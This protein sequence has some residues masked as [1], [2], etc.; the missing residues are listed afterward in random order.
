MEP[1]VT[2][3]GRAWG[4]QEKVRILQLSI[5]TDASGVAWGAHVH[6]KWDSTQTRGNIPLTP[7]T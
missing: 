2:D 6:S 7:T 3:Q 4:P 1:P 5:S